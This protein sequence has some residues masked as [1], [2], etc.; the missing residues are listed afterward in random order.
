MAQISTTKSPRVPNG[1]LN[2][3]W[4]AFPT[5][6]VQRDVS[7]Q[8]SFSFLNDQEEPKARMPTLGQANK[9]IRSELQ[10]HRINVDGNS[11]PT[12]ANQ[13]GRQIAT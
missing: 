10:E 4:N 1:K 7:D 6:I 3:T 8:V 9:I 13:K 5:R 11:R 2:V 12:D